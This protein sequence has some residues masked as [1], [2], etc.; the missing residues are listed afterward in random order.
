MVDPTPNTQF[1]REILGNFVCHSFAEALASGPFDIVIG[2]ASGDAPLRAM[3]V[4]P[5]ALVH[6]R[7]HAPRAAPQS[8][9]AVTWPRHRA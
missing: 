9:P 5:V 3:S 6:E 7:E 8:R 1:S 4:P 2:G